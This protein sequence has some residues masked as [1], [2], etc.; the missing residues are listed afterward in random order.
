MRWRAAYISPSNLKEW[1]QKM[2]IIV[3][4][5]CYANCFIPSGS[6]SW[7]AHFPIK[8][9]KKCVPKTWSSPSLTFCKWPTRLYHLWAY[10]CSKQSSRSSCGQYYNSLLSKHRAEPSHINHD[11]NCIAKHSELLFL[12]KISLHRQSFSVTWYKVPFQ[13]ATPIP[14][15]I[16]PSNPYCL[17]SHLTIVQTHQARQHQ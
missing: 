2:V 3:W 12:S 10:I 11:Q 17:W 6:S 8:L 13:Q 16:T 1:K 5:S 15:T 4:L 9:G 7:A 14:D